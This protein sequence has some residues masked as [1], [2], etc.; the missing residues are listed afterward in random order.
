[1]G[2]LSQAANNWTPAG[3]RLIFGSTGRTSTIT[4]EYAVTQWLGK[5]GNDRHANAQIV[6][7]LSVIP[8]MEK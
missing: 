8:L 6:L 4:L 1:M 3:Y 5:S 7:S 2:G